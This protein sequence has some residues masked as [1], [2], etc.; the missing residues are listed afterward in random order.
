[1]TAQKPVSVIETVNRY[2]REDNSNVHRGVHTLGSRATD[3]YEDAREKVR[4]FI[5]AD[6]TAEIIFTRGT[7]T[8]INMIAHSYGREN[9]ARRDDIVLRAMEHHR[10][11][12]P[13]QRVAKATGGKRK[14]IPM[15][16]D[17][18]LPLADVQVPVTAATEV[19]AISHVSNVLGTIIPVK[20]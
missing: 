18:T 7:T 19:V 6:S 2:Y 1:A 13:W 5:N 16:P 14:Y 11:I 4:R 20:D 9:V 8:S 10:S 17:R 15:Q 12:S 3:Q